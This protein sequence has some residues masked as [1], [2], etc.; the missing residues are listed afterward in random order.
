MTAGDFD[1]N[2]IFRLSPSGE[3]ESENEILFPIISYLLW[4]TFLIIVPI[5][6]INM[7]VRSQANHKENWRAL[8]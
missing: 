8:N 1:F 5:L 7:L 2:T 3:S 4:I 6:F